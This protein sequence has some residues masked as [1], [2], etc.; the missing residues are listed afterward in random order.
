VTTKS[1]RRSIRHETLKCALSMS[2]ACTTIPSL[3]RSAPAQMPQSCHATNL[4]AVVET[5]D[6]RN[7]RAHLICRGRRGC[8]GSQ[9]S[10]KDRLPGDDQG[11]GR[12]W[13]ER[14]ANCV[15]Q[16]RGHRRL[17]T[18]QARGE[19]KALQSPLLL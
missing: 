1:S 13:R 12:R 14:H 5:A 17:P 3:P 6:S 19:S 15:Q 2:F 18:F 11:L 16:G 7:A 9:G 8:T 4:L 10:G